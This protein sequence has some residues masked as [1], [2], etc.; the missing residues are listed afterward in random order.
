MEVRGKW[1]EAGGD[2]R[3]ESGVRSE[4]MKSP[5]LEMV[6]KAIEELLKSEE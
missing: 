2:K 1:V 4:G 6:S 5:M 3:E